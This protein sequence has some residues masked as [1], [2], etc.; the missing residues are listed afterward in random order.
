M[1]LPTHIP[2]FVLLVLL[3]AVPTRAA[4]PKP[5][6]AMPTVTS[7]VFPNRAFSIL[8]CGAVGDGKTLNTAAFAKAIAACTAAGGGVV[9]VPRG[10]YVT[11]AVNL[12]NNVN[13]H[14]EAGAEIRGSENFDDFLPP[15]LTR[16]EGLELYNYSPLIYALDC[17]NIA[18]TGP[19]VINGSGHA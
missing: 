13:L 17:T 4:E 16:F 19:G 2:S 11:G 3:L 6:F 5:P 9:V 15:V 7:P 12:K 10:V 1:K 18:L 8:D 14:L